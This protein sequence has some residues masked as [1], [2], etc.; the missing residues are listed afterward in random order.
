MKA[1]APGA[2]A[3]GHP[4]LAGMTS[5][6]GANCAMGPGMG[7]GMGGMQP[8][9]MGMSPMQQQQAM[10]QQQLMY[11]QQMMMQQMQQQQNMQQQGPR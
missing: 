11:Q 10:M 2:A 7:G 4:D 5:G 9:A 6:F 8:Q 1:V 3:A